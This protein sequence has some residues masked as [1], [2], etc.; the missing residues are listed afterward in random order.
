MKSCEQGVSTVLALLQL[1]ALVSV[2]TV[3]Q[4][5]NLLQFFFTVTVIN[6]N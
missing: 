1:I 2:L 5:I 3:G 4:Q 6:V